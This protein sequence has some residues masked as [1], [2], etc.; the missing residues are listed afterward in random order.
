MKKA[1]VPLPAS[2][3]VTRMGGD[4]DR[5]HVE[6]SRVH[7]GEYLCRLGDHGVA[8]DGLRQMPSFWK[9]I[10]LRITA[11]ASTLSQLRTSM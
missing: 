1:A 4:G 6:M 5:G 9:K 11:S 8:V 3:A 2:N 10:L 7:V